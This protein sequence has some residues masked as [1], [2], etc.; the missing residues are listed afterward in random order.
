MRGSNDASSL[1]VLSPLT[2]ASATWALSV[3]LWDF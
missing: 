3:A 2:V 1:I